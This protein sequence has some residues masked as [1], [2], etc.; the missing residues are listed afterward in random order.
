MADLVEPRD[1]LG[2][3]RGFAS[4]SLPPGCGARVS[5][6]SLSDN[7]SVIRRLLIH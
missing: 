4:R 2:V 5:S 7:R 6:S 3:E 1:D